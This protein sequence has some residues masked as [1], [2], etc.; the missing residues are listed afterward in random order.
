MPSSMVTS[1]GTC[2]RSGPIAWAR[3]SHAR[4][5]LAELSGQVVGLAHTLLDEDPAWGAFLDNLHVAYGLKRRGMGARLLT[6]TRHAVRDWSP[7]SG[8][9]LWVLEQNSGTRAFYAAQGG[10]CVECDAVPP[11]GGD[12]ARLAGEPMGL[13]YAWRA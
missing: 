4:T 12:P 8:L 13:R 2:W 3:P 9:Y 5:I 11:P 10:V 7:S 1:P 6:L